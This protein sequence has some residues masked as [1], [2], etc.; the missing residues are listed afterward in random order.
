MSSGTVEAKLSISKSIDKKTV[1]RPSSGPASTTIETKKKKAL[2]KALHADQIDAGELAKYE[3]GPAPTE[4]QELEA[5]DE[6]EAAE[7]LLYGVTHP[8]GEKLR[9]KV[10]KL[11]S[12]AMD[13]STE[14]IKARE[15]VETVANAIEACMFDKYDGRTDGAYKAKYRDLNFN[16]KDMKNVMLRERVLNRDLK[17]SDLLSMTN[18]ELANEELKKTRKKVKEKMTRDAQPSQKLTASTTQFKCGKCKQRKC[19]YFQMQTR[20]A[21]EPLTTFVTCVNCG[22]RWKF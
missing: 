19:T 22:N 15:E 11:L 21:D 14:N 20:S 13:K 16:L 10:R 9:D 4:S 5:Y 2:E 7:N 8:T 1:Q 17:L 12:D 3:D 18:E 6:E